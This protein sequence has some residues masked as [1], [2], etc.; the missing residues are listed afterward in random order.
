MSRLATTKLKICETIIK[1]GKITWHIIAG[2]QF[3]YTDFQLQLQ[4]RYGKW[5]IIFFTRFLQRNIRLALSA[6]ENGNLVCTIL[7]IILFAELIGWCEATYWWRI[8]T[9]DMADEIRR[10]ENWT[11]WNSL[12]FK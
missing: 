11:R 12:L 8:L 9:L 4:F 10:R 2:D 5:R 3:Y 1:K 7:L 6:M